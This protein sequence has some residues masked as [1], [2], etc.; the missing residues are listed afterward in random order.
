MGFLVSNFS[1]HQVLHFPP[2]CMN[3]ERE[4]LDHTGLAKKNVNG[5][6][7]FPNQVLFRTF[8]GLLVTACRKMSTHHNL[9][10]KRR[11]VEI[12]TR[13]KPDLHTDLDVYH[14]GRDH[15]TTFC[16][17][18]LTPIPRIFSRQCPQRLSSCTLIASSTQSTT[19]LWA[20]SL[21]PPSLLKATPLTHT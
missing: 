4:T 13:S 2:F 12:T 1:W 17:L 11:R 8:H 7:F 6:F 14:M 18:Q 19:Y 20:F 16:L 10:Y 9:P 5:N 15:I 3:E 21:L